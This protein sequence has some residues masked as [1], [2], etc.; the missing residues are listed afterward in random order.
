MNIE[1]PESYQRLHGKRLKRRQLILQDIISHFDHKPILL[2][3]GCRE[4]LISE[5]E[6]RTIL[7]ALDKD[8]IWLAHLKEKGYSRIICVDLDNE[9]IDLQSGSIDILYAG[10]VIEH[11][12][13]T[14]HAIEEFHR[15]IHPKGYLFLT[16]PNLGY[17]ENLWCLFRGKQPPSL[18]H[19]H[20]ERILS[21]VGFTGIIFHEFYPRGKFRLFFR[22]SSNLRKYNSPFLFVTCRKLKENTLLVRAL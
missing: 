11:L 17:L 1:V 9:N 4:G 14:Q 13:H 15:V 10:E 16:T 6:S 22:L 20:D 5:L 8:S 7:Y 3:V 19:D 12:L 18:Y 2:D 21:D